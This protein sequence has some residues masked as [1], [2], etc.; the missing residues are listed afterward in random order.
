[1][2]AVTSART[3]TRATAGAEH[4][5]TP[6]TAPIIAAVDMSNAGRAAVE[7]AVILARELE[8]P[9]L[10]VH[11]RRGPMPF[12]GAPFYQQQL[13]KELQRTARPRSRPP[14]RTSRRGRSRS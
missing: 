1:M 4:E 8:A 7:E 10:F 9:L 13:S 12:L 2:T 5:S 3:R 14:H 11:V 6:A